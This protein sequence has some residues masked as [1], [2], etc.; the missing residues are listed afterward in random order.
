[1]A[2]PYIGSPAVHGHG[3]MVSMVVGSWCTDLDP[4]VDWESGRPRERCSVGE[5]EKN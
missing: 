2:D 3:V 4:C 1:M 5:G